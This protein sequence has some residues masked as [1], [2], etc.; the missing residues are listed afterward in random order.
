MR[1]KICY[2]R[3]AFFI[4]LLY[5]LMRPFLVNYVTPL[6]KYIFILLMVIGL[7]IALS[8]KMTRK[9]IGFIEFSLCIAF[10]AY[11]LINAFYYGGNELFGYAVERYVF[12][13][14]PVFI[15]AYYGNR[16]AWDK[17]LEFLVGFGI[18]DSA[19]SIAEFITK[20]QMFPMASRENNV[21]FITSAG[22]RIIRTYGL[23]GNYF[24]LA[25]ILCVCGLA[26]L[27]LFEMYSKKR[28]L[29]G[30]LIISIG[31]L[32]T[33]SRGYY[34]SYSIAIAFMYIYNRRKKGMTVKSI[35]KFSALFILALVA[36]Y[37]LFFTKMTFGIDFVDSILF[38]I[39]MITDWTG[40]SSNSARIEHWVNA[41]VRWKSSLLF[42]NGAC[43]TD[44]R[45]SKYV[46]V[47]ES[48]VLKRLVELGLIGTLLQYATMFL[49]L[50]KGLKK[51][52]YGN[53]IPGGAF[54]I[55][56]IVCL[57][58][59]DIVLQR[60]TALEYTIIIWSSISMLAYTTNLNTKK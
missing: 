53:E 3:S 57:L 23:Q 11:V 10:Y 35:I 56:V 17:V 4:C 43:C 24:L 5:V 22:T 42:G 12:Y 49:P 14:I 36:V 46:A 30:F 26:S 60:Y 28:Y 20:K 6:Y 33:G 2:A 47:T 29:L 50:I 8:H 32:S 19:I 27:H 45:Y 54:F 51:A 21:E 52:R 25:E 41:I 39:R 40:D 37:I 18:V 44:T 59:E 7:I 34:V 15:I 38:R 1:I 55:S 48:G 16:I 13:T 58:I 9:R 31:V